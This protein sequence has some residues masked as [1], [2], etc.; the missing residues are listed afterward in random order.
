MLIDF[1]LVNLVKVYGIIAVSK[2]ELFIISGTA[3]VNIEVNFL[4]LQS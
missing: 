3:R 1:A 2:I 4:V